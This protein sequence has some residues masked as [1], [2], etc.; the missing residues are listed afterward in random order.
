MR[1]ACLILFALIAFGVVQVAGLPIQPAYASGAP[2]KSEDP[3]APHP[4]FEYVQLDPINLP[5]IT[6]KGLTQQLSLLV[7]VEVPYGSAEEIT[8][9]KPRLADAFIQDL[10]GALGAGHGLMKDGVIN[11]QEIKKRL[12]AVATKV[13]G[14]EHKIH[15]VLL[16]VVQ[17]LPR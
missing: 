12:F 4:E 14:P 6:N 16:Q 5:I 2:K 15:D 10:Y 11:V 7:S 8:T 17:Q 13:T 1:R 9:F 3:N